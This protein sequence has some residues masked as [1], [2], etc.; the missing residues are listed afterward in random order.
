MKKGMVRTLSLAALFLLVMGRLA[1]CGER[2]S[3]VSAR[4]DFIL[5]AGSTSMETFTSALAERY[6]EIHQD[7]TVTTEFVGSA[8][9]IQAVL[10]G[11]ADIGNSSR[12]LKEQ[13][14]AAGA[15]ENIVAMDAIVVCV[16]P[17]NSVDGLTRQQ[18]EYIYTGTVTNWSQVGGENAPIVVVGREAGSGT[19]T[20]F[21]E[22]L[23]VKNECV[24]ANE[25]DSNGAVLAKV[26]SI[27]GAIGYMSLD[28]ADDT[29]VPL[30]LDGVKPT[31]GNIRSGRYFLGRSY[32]MV[33][34]GEISGQSELIQDWF[35]FVLGEEG[36]EIAVSVG[37]VPV[38]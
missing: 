23:G 2:N 19:R 6:M 22:L 27:P 24:Y 32:V 21:E 16:D 5:M 9:G 12:N 3:H 26:A 29:V 10:G 14:K 11:T 37:L 35:A 4:P 30:K 28:V 31:I 17:A 36:Q 34:R 8:A 25:L 33:T 1:G 13:E 15:V 20:A 38:K 7:V 18:L